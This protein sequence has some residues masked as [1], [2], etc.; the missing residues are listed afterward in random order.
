[1]WTFTSN[2]FVNDAYVEPDAATPGFKANALTPATKLLVVRPVPN[3]PE[4]VTTM[5]PTDAEPL[6]AS[7]P[8]DS[9]TAVSPVIVANDVPLPLIKFV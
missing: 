7:V 6:N 5:L 3:A 9:E 8:A 2:D 4:P 1:M